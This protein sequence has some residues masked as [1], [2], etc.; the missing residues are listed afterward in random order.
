MEHTDRPRT[1]PVCAGER[2]GVFF[3]SDVY[4]AIGSF[5]RQKRVML[6]GSVEE[7]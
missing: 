4:P 3:V 6:T 1:G 7:V 2:L 5:I